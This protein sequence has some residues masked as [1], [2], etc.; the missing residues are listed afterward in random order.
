MTGITEAVSGLRWLA[1]AV[2]AGLKA[3]TSEFKRREGARELGDIESFLDEA[4]GVLAQDASSLSEAVVVAAKGLISRP[5]I[6]AH[7]VASAWIKTERAQTLVKS[8]VYALLGGNVAPTEA[9]AALED[10]RAFS[11]LPEAP[12]PYAVINGAL[13]YLLQSLKRHLSVGERIQLAALQATIEQAT[14]GPPS[15]LVDR[16]VLPEV[17]RLRQRRFFGSANI[18]AEAA[19]LAERLLTGD[20]RFASPSTRARALAQ[21]ARW[22]ALDGDAELVDRALAQSRALADTEEARHAAAFVVARDHGAEGLAQIQPISPGERSTVAFQV[23]RRAEGD[24]H[25]LRWAVD[26]SISASDLDSDG[27]FALIATR[28]SE[29]AWDQALDDVRSLSASDFQATPAL[30]HV[31]AMVRVAIT[32][33]HDLR[34][35]ARST[36]PFDP[37]NFPMATT[38]AALEER[39]AARD[40]MVA[41]IEPCKSLGL[42]D[43]VIAAD[44]YAMWLA[45]RDPTTRHAARDELE[46]RLRGQDMVAYLPLALAFGLKVDRSAAGALLDRRRAL[47]PAGS[48]DDAFA[49]LALA[50]SEPTVEAAAAAIEKYGEEFS[51]HL[52]PAGLL[53]IEVELFSRSG[54]ADAARRRL[55]AA[56]GTVAPVVAERLAKLVERDGDEAPIDQLIEDFEA[57]GLTPTL[58]RLVNGLQQQGY[59]ERYF[60]YASE[61]VKRTNEVSDAE[62]VAAFLLGA[63]KFVEA[64][65]IVETAA[66]LVGQ[67]PSLQSALAVTHYFAGRFKAADQILEDLPE[68][69]HWRDGRYLRFNLL[70]ASGRWAELAA[71][72][73]AEWV[74]RDE[75]SA[76]DLVQ[77]AGLA[78]SIGSSRV[79]EMLRTAVA[80]S[81]DDASVLSGAYFVATRAGIETSETGAW[82]NRAIALSKEDG[83]FR[84]VSLK[85][86]VE[87]QPRWNQHVGDVW[88]KVAEGKVPQS[89]AAIALRQRALALSLRPLLLNRELPSG[90]RRSIVPLFSGGRPQASPHPVPDRIGLDRTAVVTLAY[91]GLLGEAIR[92]FAP[93]RVEHGLLSWLFE[94][95]R[96]LPFHQPTRMADAEAL[97]RLVQ[98]QVVVPFDNGAQAGSELARQVGDE[99]AAM[100]A[101]A[102][103]RKAPR[104][105]VVSRYPVPRIGSL[106]QEE[107]DLRDYDGSLCSCNAIVDRL[108]AAGR[109][110]RAEI[111][112]ARGYLARQGDVRWPNEPEIPEGATLYVSDLALNH[113]RS[114]GLLERLAGAGLNVY[115]SGEAVAEASALLDYR[116]NQQQIL[117][118]IEAMRLALAG[119][120]ES[121]AVQVDPSVGPSDD[122]IDPG[123]AT[124]RLT[125]FTDAVV[126]DDRFI[127]RWD[128]IDHD[129]RLTPVLTSLDLLDALRQRGILDDAAYFAARTDL[130]RGGALFVPVSGEELV[131][132]ISTATAG[133]SGLR[134]TA[135]LTAIREAMLLALGRGWLQLPA[136]AGWL[137]S[138]TN[139]ATDAI[140]DQWRDDVPDEL[141]RARSSWLAELYDIRDW[142]AT[143]VQTPGLG[144]SRDG[145]PIMLT[146]LATIYRDILKTR[147]TAYAAW[148]SEAVIEPLRELE[149]ATYDRF[150]ELL[151]E[152]L[153]PA[154]IEGLPD[155]G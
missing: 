61:L 15:E 82:M 115:A 136:E 139:A 16:L 69:K 66:S 75:R 31:A 4:L 118:V 22:L 3:V 76:G 110:T 148:L 57:D 143:G 135:E 80:K 28:A 113:L 90:H 49:R 153:D 58:A 100:L 48:A 64:E 99:L 147:R 71:F 41:S 88:Q 132:H 27:K 103:I 53:S 34:G 102:A 149:P 67:S 127:N 25:A 38:P 83:P 154:A 9:A 55:K 126:A 7:E 141:A 131:Y 78:T 134:E 87:E 46:P 70:V 21:C 45:L 120:I 104:A 74:K 137:H 133:P 20:Y 36:V 89:G 92:A 1:P 107:A 119:G 109:L 47:N 33:P 97:I 151:R 73:E 54:R 96:E 60:H 85:E 62:E 59:S 106:L 129:G 50:V 65:S 43:E 5:D 14:T 77:L 117:D 108:E 12:L 23:M 13:E 114:A 142:S 8:A 112:T 128:N 152:L 40:L 155:D 35:L 146:K 6:F 18:K 29:G 144:L 52:D 56:A 124:I 140:K 84:S 121:G 145:L 24:S 111:E 72:V 123:L 30:Y 101:A 19:Q 44:V 17:E 42:K 150:L 105:L 2:T 91:L 10:Y 116:A 93:V 26:A 32:I 11:D 51:P 95:R 63:G 94:E 81:D 86:L 122:P 68:A 39:R 125:R 37:A 138:V 98:R 130:R 79:A